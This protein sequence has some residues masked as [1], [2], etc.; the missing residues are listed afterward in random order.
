MTC[1]PNRASAPGLR[2]QPLAKKRLEA[3]YLAALVVVHLPSTDDH[4]GRIALP[5]DRTDSIA[6]SQ[7]QIRRQA[8]L[9]GDRPTRRGGAEEHILGLSADLEDPPE[10]IRILDGFE[11]LVPFRQRDAGIVNVMQP[12]DRPHGDWLPPFVKCHQVILETGARHFGRVADG[13]PL[14]A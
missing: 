14:L 3:L 11:N 8:S 10:P 6:G 2:S 9:A 1:W 4:P 12:P 13:L 7:G 5:A